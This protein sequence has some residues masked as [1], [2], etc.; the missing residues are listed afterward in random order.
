MST[1][2]NKEKLIAGA[3]KLVEKGQFDK[4]I[5]EY[6]KVVAED[7]SDVRGWIRVGDLYVKL[8]QKSE[9]VENYKK[10]AQL[11]AE[12]GEPEKA[13]AVYKQIL[14]IEPSTLEA[15]MLLAALYRDMGRLQ[16][17][18]QQYEQVAQLYTRAG[19]LREALKAEQAIVDMVPDNIARRIKLAEL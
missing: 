2:S 15:H 17:A 9:A 13:V 1:N 12:Q 7:E 4:A 5:R 6:L 14:Q 3:Q 19:K 18:S 8:G 16:H 10:V 11:Y